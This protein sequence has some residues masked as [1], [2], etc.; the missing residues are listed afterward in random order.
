MFQNIEW[1]WIAAIVVV[2][3]ALFACIAYVLR[4]YK[5]DEKTMATVNGVIGGMSTML[6]AVADNSAYAPLNIV[7]LVAQLVEKS[8]LAAENAYYNDQIDAEQRKFYCI[9]KLLD[10]LKAYNIEL[11]DAQMQ[12]VDTLIAAECEQMGHTYV[13]E[14]EEGE[15][16]DCNA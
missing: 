10:L 9:D 4:K 5:I 14:E 11:T 6:K 15:K 8:V 3:M 12:T 16:D 2:F 1:Y 7:S 13:I